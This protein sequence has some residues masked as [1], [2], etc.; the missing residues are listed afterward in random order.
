MCQVSSGFIDACA[1]RFSAADAY[2]IL[3]E[4]ARRRIAYEPAGASVRFVE[5]TDVPD[6]SDV[7]GHHFWAAVFAEAY[8]HG[9]RMLKAILLSIDDSLFPSEARDERVNRLRCLESENG[10]SS[11]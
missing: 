4:A 2:Q 5:A 7:G 9:P 1:K 6:H 3:E 8:A 11:E 10:P